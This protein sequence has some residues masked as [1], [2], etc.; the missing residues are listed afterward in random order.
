MA[1]LKKRYIRIDDIERYTTLSRGELL[2]EVEAGQLS[3]CFKF[4]R[5]N[6]GAM[7]GHDDPRGIGAIFSYSGMV[8]LSSQD[9]K[10]FAKDL[11]PIKVNTVSVTQLDQVKAWRSVVVVFGQPDQDRI[12]YQPFSAPQPAQPFSA[13]INIQ[14]VMNTKKQFVQLLDMF[15]Q[16]AGSHAKQITTPK[17]THCLATESLQI[18]YEMLRVD[19]AQLNQVQLLASAFDGLPEKPLPQTQ[20]HV[21]DSTPNALMMDSHPIRAIIANVLNE[22]GNL[23]PRAV[24]NLIRQDVQHETHLYDKDGM[25]FD[26]TQDDLSYFGLGDVTKTI[27]FR[28]FQNELSKVRSAMLPHASVKK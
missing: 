28:T 12:P 21:T 16:A 19:L 13:Y 27:V 4:A 20:K 6:M 2:D 11:Q 22:H 18:T 25:I 8:S 7:V 1:A 15:N 14:S 9:A 3:F 10:Q 17:S 5:P 23:K 24:W 26:M